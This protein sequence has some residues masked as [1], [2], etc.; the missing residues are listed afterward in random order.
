MSNHYIVFTNSHKCHNQKESFC[1]NILPQNKQFD[2]ISL[3]AS[4]GF[5]AVHF[6][7]VSWSFWFSVISLWELLKMLSGMLLEDDFKLKC[8]FK[9]VCT[10]CRQL[11]FMEY[12]CALAQS[13][14]EKKCQC[15][16]TEL[17]QKCPIPVSTAN[18]NIVFYQKS[19]ISL[20]KK[21]IF[22]WIISHKWTINLTNDLSLPVEA[23]LLL[24]LLL[25]LSLF[26]LEFFSVTNR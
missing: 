19:S 2:T 8:P 11:I 20:G 4:L 12:V 5:T 6:I 25:F 17:A 26:G 3:M 1:L 10:W 16:H 14:V 9:S 13:N 23:L 18:V 21:S 7:A 24:F 15:M 22:V